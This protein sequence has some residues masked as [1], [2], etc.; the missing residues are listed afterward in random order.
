ME[1]TKK[2]DGD[3]LPL[4]SAGRRASSGGGEADGVAWEDL[5]KAAFFVIEGFCSIVNQ[6]FPTEAN[7][8]AKM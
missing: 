6:K 8:K 4:P 1:E 7:K 3:A 5:P 2:M